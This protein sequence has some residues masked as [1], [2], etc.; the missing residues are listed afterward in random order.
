MQL[1]VEQQCTRSGGFLL[2]GVHVLSVFDLVFTLFHIAQGGIELNPIMALALK[3]GYVS[4]GVIKVCLTTLGLLV[5]FL[6]L[7]LRPV[8]SLLT[9]AFLIYLGVFAWH[10]YLQ[11]IIR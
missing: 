9:F 6:H 5:L 7:H 2:V 3:N 11:F 8:R 10:I 1:P 4:F